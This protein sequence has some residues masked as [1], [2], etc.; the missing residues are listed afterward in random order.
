MKAA[1]AWLRLT[2]LLEEE[3]AARGTR[4]EGMSS[5]DDVATFV[6]S[7]HECGGHRESDMAEMQM[8]EDFAKS[9]VGDRQSR[10]ARRR[11]TRRTDH[12]TP[13]VRIAHRHRG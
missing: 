2:G 4:G 7:A 13:T 10:S 1:E 3:A 9:N 5:R 6:P 11:T 8:A 12:S